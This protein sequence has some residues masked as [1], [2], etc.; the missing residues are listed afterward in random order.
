MTASPDVKDVANYFIWRANNSEQSLGIDAA[1]TNM[2]LQKLLY[3]AQ[4]YNLALFGKVIFHD[5]ISAWEHGPVVGEL[6]HEFREY[7]SNPV[8][9]VGNFSPNSIDSRTRSILERVF[10]EYGRR[11]AWELRELTHSEIPWLSTPQKKVISV[12]KMDDYFKTKLVS[13]EPMP[14]LPESLTAVEREHI[15][16]SMISS[17]ALEGIYATREEAEHALDLALSMPVVKIG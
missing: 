11:S 3:Y 9:I 17:Q 14:K 4:G 13:M 6:Y 7:G 8:Q 15:L 10:E 16:R 2:K 12:T 1:I 5:F